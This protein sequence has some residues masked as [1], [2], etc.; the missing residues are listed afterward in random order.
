MT[1]HVHSYLLTEACI[2]FLYMLPLIFFLRNAEHFGECCK[3]P[4]VCIDQRIAP[5]ENVITQQWNSPPPTHT[6]AHAR[7]SARTQART[8][9]SKQASTYA[10]THVYTHTHTHI[11]FCSFQ[12]TIAN[13]FLTATRSLLP[14]T[15]LS[16]ESAL[17]KPGTRFLPFHHGDCEEFA[18]DWSI[19]ITPHNIITKA[20]AQDIRKESRKPSIDKMSAAREPPHSPLPP[21]LRPPPPRPVPV[22]TVMCWFELPKEKKEKKWRRKKR[23]RWLRGNTVIAQ[24]GVQFWCFR[25]SSQMYVL[26]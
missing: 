16:V 23:R 26:G 8:H 14:Y 19:K 17:S 22:A 3:V 12:Q 20:N 6:H 13:F 11:Y 9:A 18:E 25:A 7:T 2:T 4:W 1:Q 21:L 24:L 15:D 5:Y 10:R